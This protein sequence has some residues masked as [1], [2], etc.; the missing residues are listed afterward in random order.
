MAYKG[1]GGGC[2][3]MQ[4]TALYSIANL[5]FGKKCELLSAFP[6]RVGEAPESLQGQPSIWSLYV[7][8]LVSIVP[9]IRHTLVG[10]E[11]LDKNLSLVSINHDDQHWKALSSSYSKGRREASISLEGPI[12]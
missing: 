11:F 7:W 12:F 8:S 2:Y 6:A 9:N 3:G 4:G 5:A 1:G 10:V